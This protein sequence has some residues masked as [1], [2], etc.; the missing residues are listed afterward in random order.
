MAVVVALSTTCFT[1]FDVLPAKFES[2]PYTALIALVPTLSVEVVKLAEP[3]LNVPVP[4][5]VVPFLNV[6]VSPSG[7]APALD[8]TTA[9]KV[10][11]CP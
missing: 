1:A 4:R 10:T 7:G 2:P 3:P 5:T 11:A 6:T 9:V 8:V